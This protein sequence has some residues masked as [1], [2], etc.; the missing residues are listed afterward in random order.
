MRKLQFVSALF[1]VLGA[2]A[3]IGPLRSLLR[4]GA[5]VYAVDLPRPE[6]W[7]QL[8]AHARASPGRLRVPVPIGTLAYADGASRGRC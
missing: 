5:T 2:A 1:V 7:R 8:I 3:E 4:W 6:A